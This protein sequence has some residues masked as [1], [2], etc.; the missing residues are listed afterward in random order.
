MA[1]PAIATVIGAL[2]F[3][4]H[5]SRDIFRRAIALYRRNWRVFAGI[6]LVAVPIGVAF[7]LVQFGWLIA[8]L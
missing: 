6:G 8:N 5:R 4:F 3:L 2:V 7:N 1:I